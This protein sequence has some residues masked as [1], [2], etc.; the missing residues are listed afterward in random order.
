MARHAN[1]SRNTSRRTAP[2]DGPGKVFAMK[3]LIIH[4]VFTRETLEQW[5]IWA[6]DERGKEIRPGLALVVVLL[7]AIVFAIIFSLPTPEQKVKP[8]PTGNTAMKITFAPQ[9]GTGSAPLIKGRP[10][11][12]TPLKGARDGVKKNQPTKKSTVNFGAQSESSAVKVLPNFT[13]APDLEA[14]QSEPDA[15][16]DS[17]KD[18]PEASPPPASL[19]P[20]G[21][22]KNLRSLL[23]GANSTYLDTQRHIGQAIG[24]GPVGGDIEADSEVKVSPDGRTVE[25]TFNYAAYYDGLSRRFSEAWGGTRILPPDANFNGIVGEFI[26]YDFV[27]NRDGSLRKIINASAINQPHRNF[28]A[29]DLMVADA[30][31][32]MFPLNPVPAR[33]TKNPVLLRKRIH[34]G[35]TSYIMF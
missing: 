8:I 24:E 30:A 17:P 22:S 7:H 28:E 15:L 2:A 3:P 27:I 16:P 9:T 19:E 10:G 35:G 29:V 4:H 26:E 34:F 18:S 11:K 20:L 14:P 1:E 5:G 31:K 12:V 13:E 25:H 21:V 32:K 6:F 23:P 33:I